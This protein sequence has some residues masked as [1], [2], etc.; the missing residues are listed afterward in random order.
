M[1]L[2]TASHQGAPLQGVLR[3]NIVPI[4]LAVVIIA[5]SSRIPVPGLDLATAGAQSRH[6][7][8]ESIQRFSIFALGVM[9]LFTV[10]AHIEIVKVLFPPLARWQARSARNAGT[11]HAIGAVLT[12]LV[13]A[14]TGYG[15]VQ[16]F[17]AMGLMAKDDASMAAGVGSFV[18][19]SLI[20]VALADRI[21]LPGL[22][23]GVWVLLAITALADLPR[24]FA[25]D[26]ELTRLGAISGTVW[27]VAIA[28]LIAA[29]AMVAVA[30]HL[31]FKVGPLGVA[32]E[33]IS[34]SVLLW[35]PVLANTVAGYLIAV[36]VALWHE[37]LGTFLAGNFATLVVTAILIPLFAYAY[38]RILSGPMSDAQRDA[39]RRAVVVVVLVQVLI[40]VGFSILSTQAPLSIVL[41]GAMV[42][43]CV[44][45][46]QVLAAAFVQRYR[47]GQRG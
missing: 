38:W 45:V 11:V 9:P 21:R 16:A 27:M 26:V 35:P 14:I 2:S 17:A 28:F 12:L 15:V 1:N 33:P 42:I 31:L 47:I 30:N 32:G 24:S 46:L 22:E 37:Q 10:L 3:R 29:T 5:L 25:A 39:F 13:T 43:A 8:G 41:P 34:L 23:S 7:G 19:M 18:A 40:S 36:L 4:V 20:L 44:T 6:T